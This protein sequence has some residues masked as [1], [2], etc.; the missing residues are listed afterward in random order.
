MVLLIRGGGAPLGIDDDLVKLLLFISANCLLISANCF[1][2]LGEL[3]I[4]GGGAPLG[5]DDDLVEL[6]LE[7]LVGVVD[8]QL[9]ERVM[10]DFIMNS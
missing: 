7:L 8:A 4:R 5:I 1:R 9:L 2:N 6:L 10:N 3:L